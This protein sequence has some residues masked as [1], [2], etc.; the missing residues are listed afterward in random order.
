M[1]NGGQ[2]P[3]K[4]KNLAID[5]VPAIRRSPR[6]PCEKQRKINVIRRSVLFIL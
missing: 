6:F 4:A 3:K 2:K 5:P 1:Q